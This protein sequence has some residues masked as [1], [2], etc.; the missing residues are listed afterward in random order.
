MLFRI[1]ADELDE[2]TSAKL[3]KMVAAKEHVLVKHVLPHGNPHFHLY[4]NDP[5]QM[6]C[7]AMRYTLDKV[8]KCKG[9]QRSVKECEKERAAEYL[10]YLFNTK[11]GN[12]ATIISTTLD[13][14]EYQSKAAVVSQEFADTVKSRKAKDVTSWQMSEEVRQ[15][16]LAHGEEIRSEED[17]Y[18]VHIIYAIQVCRKYKKTFTDF[19]I[20]RIVQTAVCSDSKNQEI[21]VRNVIARICRDR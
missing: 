9:P 16:Y 15:L 11:H 12:V 17:I 14:A 4:L 3:I 1:R 10:Q 5:C 20:Q 8:I 13:V 21:F 18:R 6:S 2:E 7:P 19:S